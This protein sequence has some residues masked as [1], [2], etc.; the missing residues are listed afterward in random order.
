MER[1]ILNGVDSANLPPVLVDYAHTQ[2]VWTT[3][4]RQRVRSAPGV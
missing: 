1:V 3:H 4:S 2:M